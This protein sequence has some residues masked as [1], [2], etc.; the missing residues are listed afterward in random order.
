LSAEKLVEIRWHGRGGQGAVTA[1]EILAEAAW[2]EGR[3]FQAFPD[4]GGERMG[5]PIRA[6]TRISDSY[7]LQHSQIVNPDAV[8]VLDTTLFSLMDVTE[9][10]KDDGAL[11]VNTSESPADIRKALKL[12]KAR[13]Y[14]VDASRI[15]VDTLG[16]DIPNTPMIG[17]IVKATGVVSREGVL[18]TIRERLGTRLGKTMA[19]ANAKAVERAF[20]ETQQG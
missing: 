3:Y 7:I 10:L 16:R 13:V 15:A 6:Y 5:A 8:A 9:G 14:T 20:D 18:R 17:A 19:E 11:V 1:S 2:E 12:D 4:Y